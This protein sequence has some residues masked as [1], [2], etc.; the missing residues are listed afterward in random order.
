[1]GSVVS[2]SAILHTAGIPD[3]KAFDD[4]LYIEGN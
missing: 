3:P 4:T 1:M 2:R